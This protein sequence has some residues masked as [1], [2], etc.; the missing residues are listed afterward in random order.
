MTWCSQTA[1]TYN[2]DYT[3]DF[4]FRCRQALVPAQWVYWFCKSRNEFVFTVSA[5]APSVAGVMCC[6]FLFHSKMAL[7][8]E[9]EARKDPTLIT[10]SKSWVFMASQ[11]C[12]VS[13]PTCSAHI[14]FSSWELG[15]APGTLLEGWLRSGTGWLHRL[16]VILAPRPENSPDRPLPLLFPVL[17]SQ[18]LYSLWYLS[19]PR[20]FYFV[21]SA[22]SL[23][24]FCHP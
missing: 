4:V 23:S 10:S 13:L 14:F 24:P 12:R 18:L 7:S 8:S 20:L 6:D 17:I 22:H 3:A 16:E 9:L 5:V 2:S 1:F 15:G 21:L 11:L 19:A